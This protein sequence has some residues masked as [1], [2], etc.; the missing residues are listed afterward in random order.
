MFRPEPQ[1]HC[2]M[3]GNRYVRMNAEKE[4]PKL[5]TANEEHRGCGNI[6][7]FNPTPIGVLFQTVIDAARNRTGIL[8]PI[9]GG[10]PMRGHPAGTGGFQEGMDQSSEDAG[11]RELWEEIRNARINEDEIE[12]LCSRAS[13]PFIPGRR[14]NLVFGV[15]PNPIPL[16][17]FEGWEPDEE[18]LAIHISWKPEI[19]AFPSHT[20][21]L[22]KYFKRYQGVDAP[23]YYTRQPRT[24][25][26][27]VTKDGEKAVF[28]VPYVQP[29]LDAGT[30]CVQFDDRGEGHPVEWHDGWIAK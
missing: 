24:G 7:W 9:R 17:I 28:N 25:D 11:S 15:N 26:I 21:A 22:A 20:Y 3:C 18:T 8:T 2:H 23:E 5:C 30:W 6:Q 27:V 16:S 10:E 13:G 4:W 1:S 19:L 14:Q 12:L 29:M